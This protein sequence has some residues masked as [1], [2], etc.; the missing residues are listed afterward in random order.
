MG[1]FWRLIVVLGDFRE[2]VE[3]FC[4][5]LGWSRDIEYVKDNDFLT[6]GLNLDTFEYR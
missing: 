4:F 1:I 6:L 3:G 2:G 5:D